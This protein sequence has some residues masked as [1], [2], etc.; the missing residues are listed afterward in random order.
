MEWL[1]WG[2]LSN[3]APFPSVQHLSTKTGHR[4][5]GFG[6]VSGGSWPKRVPASLLEGARPENGEMEVQFGAAGIFEFVG[7]TRFNVSRSHLCDLV[8]EARHPYARLTQGEP[9]QE[10]KP[11]PALPACPGSLGDGPIRASGV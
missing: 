10:G 11:W 5:V 4:E 9:T 3:H 1:S 8:G 7:R 2:G 6:F